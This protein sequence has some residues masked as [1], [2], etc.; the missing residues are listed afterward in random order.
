MIDRAIQ[1]IEDTQWSHCGAECAACG[2]SYNSTDEHGGHLYD[3]PIVA[4]FDDL[5]IPATRLHRKEEPM[6][7]MTGPPVTLKQTD[8]LL[9]KLYR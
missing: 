9:R 7:E 4:L 6:P 3:C 2:A 1:I 5:G 8:D